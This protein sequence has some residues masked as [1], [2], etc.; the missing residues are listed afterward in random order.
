MSNFYLIKGEI[1]KIS[2]KSVMGDFIAADSY[3]TTINNEKKIVNDLIER[4]SENILDEI[5]IKLNDL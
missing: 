2:S 3:S 5:V 4:L 1:K